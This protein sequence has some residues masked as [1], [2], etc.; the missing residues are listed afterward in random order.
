[1]LLTSKT[2]A[3]DVIVKATTLNVRKIAGIVNV[4]KPSALTP[5]LI[6]FRRLLSTNIS[7]LWKNRSKLSNSYLQINWPRWWMPWI[8]VKQALVAQQIT[9]RSILVKDHLGNLQRSKVL[10]KLRSVFPH[11]ITKIPKLK[12]KSKENI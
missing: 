4:N 8:M 10:S 3:K 6:S 9:N 7:S 2:S 5:T 12:N 1:M 11:R